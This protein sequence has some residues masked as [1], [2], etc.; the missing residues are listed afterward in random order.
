MDNGDDDK[1]HAD[2]DKKVELDLPEDVHLSVQVWVHASF[3]VNRLIMLEMLSR[4][5]K[6]FFHHSRFMENSC[7]RDQKR[8]ETNA[9]QDH[10]GLTVL[11]AMKSDTTRHNSKNTKDVDI[12]PPKEASLAVFP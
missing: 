7:Q 3:P 6:N 9:V 10:I 11:V 12:K 1:N 5:K 4:D 8:G 2:T